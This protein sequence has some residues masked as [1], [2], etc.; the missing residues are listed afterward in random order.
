MINK[1]ENWDSVEPN[2]GERKTL[3]P[4]GYIC[5]VI[6]TAIEKS[7]NGNDMLVINF[8]IAEGDDK[9]YYMKR[10]KE[11]PRTNGTEPKWGGKYY[12]VIDVEGYEGRL[13]AFTTSL[14][15]SNPGYKWDWNE[16]NIKGKLMGGIFREEEYISNGEIRTSCK[17]WQVRS[18]A[19]IR[20]GEFEVPRKKEISD[21]EREKIEERTSAPFT[22]EAFVPVTDDDLPF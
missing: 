5:Q 18:V 17:L 16:E 22:A 21:D 3:K 14:E 15:E 9:G 7:K 19:T 1:I 11:A 4:G 8:D 2:Y 20:S 6:A 13:K 12:I 10:Y